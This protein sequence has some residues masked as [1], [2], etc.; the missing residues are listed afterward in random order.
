[1]STRRTRGQKGGYLGAVTAKGGVDKRRMGTWEERNSILYTNPTSNWGWAAMDGNESTRGKFRSHVPI[2]LLF[3][4][5]PFNSHKLI[6]R[7]KVV[8]RS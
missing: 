5:D 6:H 1:M 2:A 8:T 3:L 7:R 4:S